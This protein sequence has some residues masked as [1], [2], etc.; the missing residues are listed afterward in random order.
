MIAISVL[1]EEIRHLRE[2]NRIQRKSLEDIRIKMR[3]KHT[4]CPGCGVKNGMKHDYS[5]SF[6]AGL[7]ATWR[8][9]G[10]RLSEKDKQ[11]RGEEE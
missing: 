3:D 8:A 4:D 6:T 7:E 2:I 9:Q 11:L 10:M 1:E 5:C